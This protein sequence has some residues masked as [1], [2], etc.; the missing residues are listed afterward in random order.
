M[1]APDLVPVGQIRKLPEGQSVVVIDPPYLEGAEDI[2]VGDQV[3]I[4]YWMHELEPRSRKVLKVHP[5][6]D[7]S[8]A[9]RGVFS[10]RSPMRPNP[11]GVSLARVDRVEGNRLFV[12]GL[13]A[14]DGSPLLDIKGS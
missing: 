13:D 10:L 14:L 5:R 3:Q 11:I 9:R 6:G 1:L 2:G 12:C 4:L 8:R 7:K